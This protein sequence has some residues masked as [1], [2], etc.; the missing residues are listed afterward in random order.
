M[1]RKSLYT[2]SK[3]RERKV[4]SEDRDEQPGLECF[5]RSIEADRDGGSWR[6]RCR[7]HRAERL[8]PQGRRTFLHPDAMVE[9]KIVEGLSK[10]A[11]QTNCCTHGR[12]CAA[13]AEE[14]FFAVLRQKS[15][16]GLYHAELSAGLGFHGD[17]RADRVPVAFFASEPKRNG[18]RQVARRI[19]Q[20]ANLRDATI[21]QNHFQPAVVI[22]IGERE[23]AAVFDEVQTNDTRHVGERSV[24]IV[25]IKDVAFESTPGAIAA[26][27]LVNGVPSLFVFVVGPGVL[28]RVGD[29]LAPKET[30][31][32]VASGTGYHAVGDV[33]VGET[34]TIE[35]PEVAGPRPAAH[36]GSR[37]RAY[38][39]EVAVAAIVKQ[40][41]AHCVF[42]IKRAHVRG[43]VFLKD[44]L[45]R[46]AETR[47]RPHDGDVDVFA[48]IVRK[49]PPT[50]A[51]ARAHVL[52]T[53]VGG[54]IGE[55]AVATI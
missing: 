41:V 2:P 17:G 12:F 30:V 21:L 31:Q 4:G 10:T 18:R 44:V 36:G 24:A 3:S 15:R 49:I 22:K 29:N 26:D 20:K 14:Q 5:G 39:V 43:C 55:S 28:R 23:S 52:N 32:V 8:Y 13:E 7:R 25:Q 47:G 38:I 1:K 37:A 19:F 48:A 11:W 42:A 16:T 46:D 51:H 6:V 53:G 27:Q 33:E 40:A 54:D 50:A 45:L 35:I 9:W 34:V